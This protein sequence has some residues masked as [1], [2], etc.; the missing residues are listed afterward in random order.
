[1]TYFE[2]NN[3]RNGWGRFRYKNMHCRTIR[4]Y[5]TR[6]Q[7]ACQ[8]GLA[9]ACCRR[10]LRLQTDFTVA[11]VKSPGFL[12]F[13]LIELLVVIAI[14]AILASLLLPVLGR[15]KESSRT[16]ACASN[17]HQIGVA[18][19]TYSMDNNGNIPSFRNWLYNAR[20]GDLTTGRLFPYLKSKP[21]YLC[22]TDRIEL[23]SRRRTSAPPPSGFGSVNSARDYS[24]SMNCGI[25]HAT[26]LAK[27]L[28]PSQTLLYMEASLATNDYSG[29]I[30]PTFQVRSLALRHG[31]RGHLI[32]GDLH[33]AKMDKKEYDKAE[34][35]KR[36]WFPTDDT[37]GPGGMGMGNG[38][39]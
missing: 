28:A 19:M 29:M 17:L 25:C 16:A 38:L 20:P 18:S 27:F 36:F 37:S 23:A 6:G 9:P 8:R 34:K 33:M 26:D 11:S 22:P 13:T 7:V 30:G 14:I 31:K 10:S 1:M 2:R 32:L 21:V 4:V 39:Q 35:T 15:A 12:A 24:Y 3:S 5:R